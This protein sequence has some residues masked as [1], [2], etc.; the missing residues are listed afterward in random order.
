MRILVCGS[1]DWTD[2]KSIRSVLEKYTDVTLI[3]GGCRGADQLAFK[4][5]KDLGFQNVVFEAEWG[6]YGRSAGPIRNRRMLDEGRPDLVIAFHE[7][8]VRSKG[9]KNMVSI[10][11]AKNVPVICYKS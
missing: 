11:K 10:A 4:I 2:E 5:G 9:T 3:T 6:S 8:L 7:D 1:R